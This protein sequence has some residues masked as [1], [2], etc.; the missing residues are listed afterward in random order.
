MK[1]FH[2][3][4]LPRSGHDASPLSQLLV[5]GRECCLWVSQCFRTTKPRGNN[6]KNDKETTSYWFGSSV[7]TSLC[8]LRQISTLRTPD[9]SR[10]ICLSTADLSSVDPSFPAMICCPRCVSHTDPIPQV[11]AQ[12]PCRTDHTYHTEHTHHADHA[13]HQQHGDMVCPLWAVL[14]LYTSILYI[15]YIY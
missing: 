6:N 9:R 8:R 10:Y 12:E 11:Y 7:R 5:R 14:Q 2:A 4:R 13:D 3:T 1:G 15:Y